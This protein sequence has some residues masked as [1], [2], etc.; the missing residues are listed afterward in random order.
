[1]STNSGLREA[2]PTWS[3]VVGSEEVERALQ[4]AWG[5]TLKVAVGAAGVRLSIMS[6]QAADVKAAVN[7][8]NR[9]RLQPT[10]TAAA[11]AAAATEAAAAAALR[12]SSSSS[13]S[14]PAVQRLAV[15]DAQLLSPGSRHVGQGT[16]ACSMS[17]AKHIFK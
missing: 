6:N 15:N 9:R 10:H 5:L 13:S 12:S 17:F 7:Q 11:P 16:L 3:G 4:H 2:P 14:H 8:R 1:M